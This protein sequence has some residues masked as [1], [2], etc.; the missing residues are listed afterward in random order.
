[1]LSLLPKNL[2]QDTDQEDDKSSDSWIPE[3]PEPYF[4]DPLYFSST[5]P[6]ELQH[7]PWALSAAFD[8][9]Y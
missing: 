2:L 6:Y 7:N 3:S 1:M 8:Y 5:D 4:G 9:P